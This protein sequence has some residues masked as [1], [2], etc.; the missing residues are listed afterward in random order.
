MRVAYFGACRKF[1]SDNGGEFSN[2]RHKEMNKLNIETATA[3][4]ESPFSSGIVELQNQILA[5]AFY[6]T[7][8]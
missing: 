5:E 2:K 8:M 4:D 6:K 3:A 1:L 7:E